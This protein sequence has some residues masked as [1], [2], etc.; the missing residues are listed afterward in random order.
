MLIQLSRKMDKLSENFNKEIKIIKR[1]L[2]ELKNI[3][4][5][6]KYTLQEINRSDNA[7]EWISNQEDRLVEITKLGDQKEKRIKEN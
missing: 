1:G 3:T 4:T 6:M 2:S 5:K 7:E